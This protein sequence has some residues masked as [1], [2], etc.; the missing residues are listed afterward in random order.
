MPREIEKPAQAVASTDYRCLIKIHLLDRPS[1]IRT[2]EPQI[3]TNH[4]GC[5]W[6]IATPPCRRGSSHLAKRLDETAD[7]S[8]P[9]RHASNFAIRV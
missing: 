9:L 2:E 5:Y 1:N 8:K 7:V 3:A 6:S 4:Q